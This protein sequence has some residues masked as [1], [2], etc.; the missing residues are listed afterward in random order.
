[1]LP[2]EKEYDVSPVYS[3]RDYGVFLLLAGVRNSY[4]IEPISLPKGLPIDASDIVKRESDDW[5][6]TAFS[7]SWLTMKELCICEQPI[8]NPELT[9]NFAYFKDRLCEHFGISCVT[10]NAEL[11]NYRI[12]F[13]FDE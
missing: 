8:G 12:V 1:M 5:G 4:Y 2:G 7:H 10:N 11:E 6:D 13:W 3:F 9:K